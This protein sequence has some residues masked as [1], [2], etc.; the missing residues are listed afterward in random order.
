M[1]LDVRTLFE[2]WL[3]NALLLGAVQLG[4]WLNQ[5]EDRVLVLW[6]LANFVCGVG[7]LLLALRG[8]IPNWLSIGGGNA[9]IFAWLLLV[10]AGM[11]RFSGFPTSPF[12]TIGAAALLFGVMQLP[13]LSDRLDLR[14]ALLSTAL[15]TVTGATAYDLWR[16]QR[17]EMLVLRRFLIGLFA[18]SAAAMWLRVVNSLGLN[19]RD[20]FL[21]VGSAPQIFLLYNNLFI[22]VWNVGALL[23]VTE[24]LQNRLTRLA[25]YDVL[26]GLLNPRAFFD[27]AESLLAGARIKDKAA[28]VLMVGLRHLHSYNHQLGHPAV[29]DCLRR[30]AQRLGTLPRSSDDLVC[31]LGGEQFA[32]L[33]LDCDLGEATGLA[34]QL[35]RNIDGLR[36]PHPGAPFGLAAAIVG[37]RAGK[38]VEFATARAAAEDADAALL[39]ARS[40]GMDRVALFLAP[41]T[42]ALPWADGAP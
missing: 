27:Q 30:I 41:E 34:A 20:D 32:V 9:L 1:T 21:S 25:T 17:S 13:A 10:W 18:F 8:H 2:L 42:F 16:A 39:R 6:G 35:C 15:A 24:R 36:I 38:A 4:V 29:E 19:P 5:R 22:V 37:I 28:A 23:M 12:L 7:S 11:R 14:T 31:R 26:T 33:L 3:I 40:S